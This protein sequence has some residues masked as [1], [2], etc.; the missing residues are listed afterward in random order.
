MQV[1]GKYRCPVPRF[2][3]SVYFPTSV[4]LVTW[5]LLPDCQVSFHW[6]CGHSLLSL[7]L[8][9]KTVVYM[10]VWCV[11]FDCQARATSVPWTN[12]CSVGP[13]AVVVPA[14]PAPRGPA[15]CH[16]AAT[17]KPKARERAN[18]PMARQLPQSNYQNEK[19]EE[20]RGLPAL[21]FNMQTNQPAGN[22]QIFISH[23][24]SRMTWKT[25]ETEETRMRR[26]D[27]EI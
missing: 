9:N 11:D 16:F 24:A 12:Y 25:T 6:N 26:K 2:R 8:S 20:P 5:Y 3:A 14:H 15:C 7:C 17:R 19:F 27:K 10:M 23:L 22:K 4:L 13:E 18:Q 21:I 1:C